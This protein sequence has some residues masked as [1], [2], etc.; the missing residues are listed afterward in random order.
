MVSFIIVGPPAEVDEVEPL[1]DRI[2]TIDAA[3]VYRVGATTKI[4]TAER[5][6]TYLTRCGYEISV[7]YFTA[8]TLT[9]TFTDRGSASESMHSRE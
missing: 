8:D 9:P 1:P 6:I 2:P 3:K 4:V 5:D 7:K